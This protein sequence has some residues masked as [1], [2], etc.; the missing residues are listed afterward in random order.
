VVAESG[1]ELG[2]E[3]RWNEGAAVDLGKEGGGSGAGYG[4]AAEFGRGQQ[5]SRGWGGGRFWQGS[6]VETGM[7]RRRIRVRQ[8]A[9]AESDM[10]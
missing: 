6:A 1:K 8:G 9:A 5:R 4:V 2:R 10:G 3:Q 7:G